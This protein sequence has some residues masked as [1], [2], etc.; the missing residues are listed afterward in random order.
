MYRMWEGLYIWIRPSKTWASSHWW[1]PYKFKECGKN[2]IY[3]SRLLKHEW[4]HTGETPYKCKECGKNFV[5]GSGL[6]KRERIHTGEK[7]HE[8]K[9]CVKTFSHAH[10]LRKHEKTH[11]AKSCQECGKIHSSIMRTS[12]DSCTLKTLTTKS[13]PRPLSYILSFLGD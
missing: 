11:M 6:L 4:I 9:E 2:F 10:Q 8:C 7:P 3:G 12:E 13:I 5:Y 1:N